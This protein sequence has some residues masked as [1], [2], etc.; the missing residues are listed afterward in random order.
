M[1]PWI[2]LCALRAMPVQLRVPQPSGCTE[3]AR[4]MAAV[5]H[6]HHGCFSAAAGG[7]PTSC[8]GGPGA[9][10]THSYN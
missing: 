4:A 6:L 5:A 1:M 7:T 2:P 3:V 8:T 9:S 10:C